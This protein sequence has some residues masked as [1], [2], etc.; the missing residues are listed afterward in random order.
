VEGIEDITK[1]EAS[2]FA[3]REY[4]AVDLGRFVSE[5]ISKMAPLAFEKGLEMKVERSV[6]LDVS[7]D[8]KKLEIIIRNI[9]SNA[10]KNTDSGGIYVDY[11]L[12]GGM[13]FVAVRDTGDG[14]PEERIPLVFERFYRG[15][16]SKGIG[17]GLAIVKELVEIMDGRVGVTSKVGEG[18]VFTVTL[19]AEERK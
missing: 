3:G 2:F 7:T 12:R 15:D 1:A 13:F 6:A 14:I 19:P 5:T 8:P 11:G 18:S 17:L 16:K 4:S 10:I 9:L